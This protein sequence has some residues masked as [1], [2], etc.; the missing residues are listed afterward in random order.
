MNLFCS[1]Q[2][3]HNHLTY[4]RFL[5][6][7]LGE[8]LLEVAVLLLLVDHS[9][10]ERP[11]ERFYQGRRGLD[12]LLIDVLYFGLHGVDFLPEELYKSMVL[13]EIFICLFGEILHKTG[14][15]STMVRWPVACV[16]FWLS[17]SGESKVLITNKNI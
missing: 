1:F 13:L 10:L 3:R 15:T 5:L 2:R 9:Q 6:L 14:L 7:Q 11:V 12:D 17:F 8:L 4:Y 16:E